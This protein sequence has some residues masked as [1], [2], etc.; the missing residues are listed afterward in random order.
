VS[1]FSQVV[2]GAGKQRHMRPRPGF[3]CCRAYDTDTQR[4]LPLPLSSVKANHKLAEE[5][6]TIVGV[7]H[8]GESDDSALGCHMV[9]ILAVLVQAAWMAR[10]SKERLQTLEGKPGKKRRR[11]SD[12]QSLA[13]L[14]PL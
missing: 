13:L 9:F 6:S 4:V 10:L 8:T 5:V 1:S 2:H 14:L 11:G 3:I 12:L 7:P